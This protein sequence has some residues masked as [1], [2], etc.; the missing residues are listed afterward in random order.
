MVTELGLTSSQ[1][2]DAER[3]ALYIWPTV[4]SVRYAI[5]LAH[6]LHRDD[7]II[8]SMS[9]LA[10]QRAMDRWF[11]EVVED[12]ACRPTL[13]E[14]DLVQRLKERCAL[15]DHWQSL[16]VMEPPRDARTS[17]SHAN[18]RN[19]PAVYMRHFDRSSGGDSDYTGHF[20]DIYRSGTFARLS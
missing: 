12:H 20:V 10:L 4:S 19:S 17:K 7:L 2:L 16:T 18:C 13:Q 14:Y 8:V 11:P 15:S 6:A 1:M 5:S 3:H 9:P